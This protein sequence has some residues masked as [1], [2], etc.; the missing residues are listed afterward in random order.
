MF[1]S[2]SSLGAGG[3][4]DLLTV[5]IALSILFACFA[6]GG[7]FSGA[8]VNSAYTSVLPTCFHSCSDQS[9]SSDPACP[10]LSAPSHS[11]STWAACGH[12]SYTRL[13]GSSSWQAVSL[14][15]E[16][17]FFGPPKVL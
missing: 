17:P 1:S 4:Q 9:Q 6:I 8:A 14:V 2:V 13:D 11:H 10:C 3:T 12:I 7:I 15:S 5:D 16:P